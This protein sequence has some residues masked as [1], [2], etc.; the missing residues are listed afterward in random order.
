MAKK[1]NTVDID[2]EDMTNEQLN[3]LSL[4][5]LG[6]AIT[7]QPTTKKPEED[8]TAE[9]E[10]TQTE[11]PG[12]EDDATTEEDP[13]EEVVDDEPEL[14]RGKSRAEVLKMLADSQVMISRQG[15]E[16]HD[17]KTEIEALKK[18]INKPVVQEKKDELMDQLADYD[19]EQIEVIKKLV[20]HETQNLT[21]AQ[22]DEQD[23]ILKANSEENETFW[24]NLEVINP[25]LSTEIKEN[26]LASIQKDK[27]GTLQKAGWLKSYITTYIASKDGKT[28][29]KK[30]D[31]TTRKLKA[32]TPGSGGQPTSTKKNVKDMTAEEY[33]E[34]AK[35][36]RA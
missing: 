24:S 18:Q 6:Q 27:Q 33:A 34:Y 31:V 22:Q 20:R 10:E 21:K 28:I 9:E 8:T 5:E 3:A 16:K 32:K 17:W 15:N 1:D 23:K 29:T 4:E 25:Q 12:I 7:K 26:V 2:V 30:P 19:Q 14:T 36:E 13:E 11:E 35:L